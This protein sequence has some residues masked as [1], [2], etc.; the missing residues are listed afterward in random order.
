M[1]NLFEQ[2]SSRLT[3][4]AVLAAMSLAASA[5]AFTHKP[6]AEPRATP[7]SLTLDDRPVTRDT[8]G[9]TT[10]APVVRKVSPAVV[11]VFTTTRI[12]PSE[13]NG[14]PGMDDMLRRFF[15]D[16]FPGQLQRGGPRMQ[17]QEGIITQWMFSKDCCLPNRNPT[18]GWRGVVK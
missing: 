1:K 6:G 12:Q 18:V 8:S 5:L 15:G 2:R 7:V 4:I 11:K 3:T 9:R 14:P 17:R 13:F 10:F 16:Q